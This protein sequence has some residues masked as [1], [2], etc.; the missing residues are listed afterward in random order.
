MT[1]LIEQSIDNA[2]RL[3]EWIRKRGGI[4]VW[5]SHDLSDPCASS[6]TPA[7][8]L[9]GNPTPTPHW[10]YGQ[11][12]ERVVTDPAEVEL[13]K[14]E[15]VQELPVALKHDGYGYLVL[16]KGSERKLDKALAAAGKGSFYRKGGPLDPVMYIY[17]GTPL[18]KTLADWMKEN[19]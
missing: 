19:P 2:P 17:R 11:A 16:T 7:L 8:D 5:K 14:D 12:P 10:K 3:A 6:L 4:A 9:L 1:A 13:Y 18:N 15:L